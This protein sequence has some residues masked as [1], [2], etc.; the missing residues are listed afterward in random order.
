L[1]RTDGIMRRHADSNER[2]AMMTDCS[3]TPSC[4]C[5]YALY[6]KK[7]KKKRDSSKPGDQFWMC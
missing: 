4:V 5:L 6:N 3:P 1:L 7:Y 2:W